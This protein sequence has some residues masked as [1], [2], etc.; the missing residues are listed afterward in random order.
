MQGNDSLPSDSVRGHSGRVY[1]SDATVDG[2]TAIGSGRRARLCSG[3]AVRHFQV[4]FEH[5]KC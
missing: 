5:I 4:S 1:K 2:Y 3:H